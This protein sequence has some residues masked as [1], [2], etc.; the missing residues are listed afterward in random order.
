MFAA[1]RCESLWR[2]GRPG[3]CL[4]PGKPVELEDTT[5]GKRIRR[6]VFVI[7]AV[8]AKAGVS[9]SLGSSGPGSG[10]TAFEL[11]RCRQESSKAVD[12]L[13]RQS[14][15]PLKERET[16][17][18]LGQSFASCRGGGIPWQVRVCRPAGASADV[19]LV[20]ALRCYKALLLATVKYSIAE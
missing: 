8:A 19:L 3:C 13:A 10:A 14:D 18:A 6:P 20:T 12:Y 17:Q 4:S 16:G 1:A 11:G 7:R 9:G 5:Q 15:T 2:C